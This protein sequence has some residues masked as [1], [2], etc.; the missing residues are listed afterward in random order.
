MTQDAFAA[1]LEQQLRTQGYAFDRAAVLAFVAPAWPLIE[2]GPDAV[3]WAQR[4][5]EAG[6]AE[7]RA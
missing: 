6:L 2:D 1:A 3:A 5:A 7:A 4:F